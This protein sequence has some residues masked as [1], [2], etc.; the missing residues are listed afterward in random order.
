MNFKIFFI[1]FICIDASSLQRQ[2]RFSRSSWRSQVSRRIDQ[3]NLLKILGH[4]KERSTKSKRDGRNKMRQFRSFE[5]ITKYIN[6]K[7][8]EDY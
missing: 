6:N 2:E 8:F 4:I 5:R 7:Q 1:L 3:K